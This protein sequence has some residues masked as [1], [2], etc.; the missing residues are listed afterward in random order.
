MNELP[1]N[2]VPDFEMDDS[3]LHFYN[4]KEVEDF[5]VLVEKER[6]FAQKFI[7][8]Q[9]EGGISPELAAVLTGLGTGLAATGI[10]FSVGAG[11]SLMGLTAAET[12]AALAAA[13][14]GAVATGGAGVA[15]G[16]S[17][18]A[19]TAVASVALP[20]IL[21]GG[22]VWGAMS[23]AKLK[24]TLKELIRLSFIYEEILKFDERREVIDFVNTVYFARKKYIK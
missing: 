11:A 21:V 23:Q 6:M 22:I 1:M 18:L 19:G 4:K 5:R 17:A 24:R 16:V 9:G 12:T 10:T 3:L 20:A 8:A 2:R 15:G 7:N 13:G 14:G